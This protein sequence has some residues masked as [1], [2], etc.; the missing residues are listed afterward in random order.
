[1]SYIDQLKQQIQEYFGK[2]GK[3]TDRK[4]GLVSDLANPKSIGLFFCISTSEELTAIRSLL[5]TIRQRKENVRAYVFA[6]SRNRI[7]VITDQSI[8]YFD[9]NDFTLLA[10][11]QDQIKS[12]FEK[13]RPELFIS[14][15]A[16]PGPFSYRLAS[17][18]HAEFKVGP[19]TEGY[20]DIYDLV[21]DVDR[22]K[23]NFIKFYEHVR[24]YL[25]VLNIKT[26]SPTT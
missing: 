21:L 6:Q 24:H 7:D 11:K 26:K 16:N 2:R 14:F 19:N 10:K 1:V 25:T 18:F 22:Q 17:E 20:T 13:N 12:I 5:R 4:T 23:F 15:I 9:L 3:I 8:N